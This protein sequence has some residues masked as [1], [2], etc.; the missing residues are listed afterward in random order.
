MKWRLN[1][2]ILFVLVLFGTLFWNIY[3]L[4]IQEGSVYAARIESLLH[5]GFLDPK[6]GSIFVTDK[7]GNQ[8]PV[9]IDREYPTIFADPEE[10]KDAAGTAALLAPIVG[11]EEA[12]LLRMFQKPNDEYELVRERVTNDMVQA[13]KDAHLKGIYLG[14]MNARFYPF[15][16][17]LAHVLGFVGPA[18]DGSVK[19]RYGLELLFDDTLRGATVDTD[20]TRNK[21]PADG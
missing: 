10:I 1:G 2:L 9:A 6:R 4:Q 15:G 16:P 7:Y 8:I 3:R 11:V 13:V 14:K 18:E 20:G 19:G 17:L 21:K 5:A 12:T